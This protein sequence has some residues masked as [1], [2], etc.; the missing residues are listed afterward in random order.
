MDI[1]SLQCFLEVA[2]VLHFRRAAERLNLSQSALSMRI[3]TL[4]DEIGAPLFERDRRHVALSP[5]GQAF[6]EPAR[7]ALTN[8]LHAKAQAR[9]A[10]R[11]ELGSLRLGFTLIAFY[12]ALP[13][14]VCA[15]RVRYPDI[16]LELIEMPSGAQELALA[17]G[18]LDI[19]LLHPPLSTAALTTRTLPREP[20][21]LAIPSSHRLASQPTIALSDLKGE[22]F[23]IAP[24]SIGSHLYDRIIALFQQAGFSPSIVQEVMP[25]TSL[26][27]LAAAGVGIGFVTEG[28]A[29]INRP[30]VVFKPLDEPVL[31]LENAVSWKLLSTVGERFLEVIAE[32][33]IT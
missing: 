29:M 6:L 4:E 16:T 8:A 19:G 25:M 22:P 26:I 13:E 32:H 3:R 12:G 24:R 33:L 20:L 9:R 11:G 2:S 14:V 30:G 27:G 23:M 7:I 21:V 15:F 31:Y 1:R 18:E 17:A 10:A 5:S 28:M